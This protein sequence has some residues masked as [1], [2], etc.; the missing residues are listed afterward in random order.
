MLFDNMTTGFALHEMLY[1]AQGTPVDY[2]FLAVNPAF[3][4]LTGLAADAIIGRTVLAVL[5]DTE[6]FW[7]ETYADVVHLGLPKLFAHYSAALGKWYEVQA[8]TL[9]PDNRFAVIIS[10]ITDR[11][12][13][14]EEKRSMEQQLLQSQKMEAIGQL[15]GGVAHDFNN[16]LTGILGNAALARSGL[17]PGDPVL[18]NIDAIEIAARNA[19]D[20][21]HGLLT[22]GRNAPV[23][24]VASSAADL[25]GQAADLLRP[26][27][28]A[29]I[30][31]VRD[32][33]PDAWNILAD[34]AQ[35][36]QILLNLAVNARDAMQGKGRITLT[37]RNTVIDTD[38]VRQHHD[39]A[40]GEYVRLS[41][42]DTGTG[43]PGEIMEHLFEPFHTTK[44]AGSGTGLG[45]S[46]V[47]GAVKQSKGWITV[48]TAAGIGTT[49][50]VYIP[51]CL[52]PVGQD[53]P[54]PA[55]AGVIARC[56]TVLVVEDEPVV[57]GVA[58]SFLR[59]SGCN[60]LLA[61]DGTQAVQTFAAQKDTGAIEL[62][63]LDMTMPGM[64]VTDIVNA[65]RKISPDVPILLN[66]GYASNDIVTSL[67]DRGLVQGFLPKP[68]APEQL[69]RTVNELLNRKARD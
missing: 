7:I 57:A 32:F 14:E 31:I 54:N 41:I 33:Q 55:S 1:D 56:S 4:R 42:Q 38:Y 50:D 45:L 40:A 24:P 39:A 23:H 59:R 46:I 3:E 48:T 63:M 6:R 47:Y 58:E 62:I 25:I 49:F 19:A 22:F 9:A 28:P 36:A 67:L 69:V 12:Q 8:F 16:M 60:V 53:E 43:I 29:T 34:R 65:L 44:P 37:I 20:L 51:R 13:A 61:A 2:R 15:A 10:D 11:K 66:S 21:T 30:E 52:L 68:Y 35:I 17:Q 5:P 64:P 27:L 26:S 18:D